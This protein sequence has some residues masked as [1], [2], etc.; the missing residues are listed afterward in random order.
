M[1]HLNIPTLEINITPDR[2]YAFSYRGV[3][4]E[5]HHST[6]EPFTD[7]IPELAA[8]APQVEAGHQGDVEAAIEDD[9][10]IHG[11]VGCDRYY[12]RAVR[13]FDPNAKTPNWMRRR[14]IR[15]GVRPH[16]LAVDVT[17]YVMLDLG[18]PLHAYDLDKLVPPIV[19][20]RAHEGEKL[21]TL[22]GEEHV[23]SVEDLVITDSPNGERSS[24]ILGLAGVM[25]GQYGEITADTKNILVESAHFDT[26][27]IARTARRHKLPTDASHRF[28]RGVD[29]AMQP[30]AAQDAFTF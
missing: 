9:N 19:V 30:A 20:R 24:R 4:R 21:V 8:Q 16:T 13:G 12:L 7:P 18:Q 10:P 6:G 29:Y 14:L 23:L 26:V 25:G 28:E 11:V 5:Y 2:G 1:L 17:N 27:S 3:A 22:D 15:A